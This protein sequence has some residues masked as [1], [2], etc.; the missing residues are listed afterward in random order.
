[1]NSLDFIS[2]FIINIL[3]I[4]PYYIFKGD[5]NINILNKYDIYAI[6]NDITI[7]IYTPSS[8]MQLLKSD[9]IINSHIL[10]TNKEKYYELLTPIDGFN[11]LIINDVIKTFK[12][13]IL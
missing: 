10:L 11:F 2:D 12:G 7:Y 8:S 1:M 6:I 13:V 3:D 4:P 9:I 5:F